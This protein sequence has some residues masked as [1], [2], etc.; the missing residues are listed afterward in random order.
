MLLL[1]APYLACPAVERKD[2]AEVLLL[3]EG[4][5]VFWLIEVEDD[6]EDAEWVEGGAVAEFCGWERCCRVAG[7]EVLS[8]TM[9]SL[10]KRVCIMSVM[11]G[12]VGLLS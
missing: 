4:V 8:C 6:E 9:A 5:L 12:M 1:S 3:Y 11:A 10:L 7:E 2:E